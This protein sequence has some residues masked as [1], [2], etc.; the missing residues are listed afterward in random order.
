LL[1]VLRDDGLT[2]GD[3]LDQLSVLQFLKLGHG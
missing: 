3:D 2:N 1:T